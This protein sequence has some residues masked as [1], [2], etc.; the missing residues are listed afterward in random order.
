MATKRK[1]PAKIAPPTTRQ[2]AKK[3]LAAN[4]NEADTAVSNIDTH[5]PDANGD[6]DAVIEIS[7]DAGSSEYDLSDEE[8]DKNGE[9]GD[10]PAKKSGSRKTQSAAKDAH[11]IPTENGATDKAASPNPNQDGESDQE[12]AEPTF[13]ERLHA[14]ETID[15]PA[16]LSALRASVPATPGKTLAPP[17]LASLGTVLAQALRTDDT[18]LLESCLHT[19][20]VQTIRNT[21]QRLDSSLAGILL[22]KLASRMHRR[23][24]RAGTLMTWVQWALIAHGGALATQ[25]NLSKKLSELNK[26]LEERSRGLNSLLALKG[27]LDLLEA[28]MQLRRSM[29]RGIEAEEDEEAG[30]EEGLIYV[31]GQESDDDMI[32]G[33]M[34]VDEDDE[35]ALANGAAED[36][37]EDEESSNGEDADDLDAVEDDMDEN[38]VDFNDNESVDDEDS[39]IEAASPVKKARR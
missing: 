37:S 25:P 12:P 31:E 4:I 8:Q 32:N 28:Q 33:G 3:P 15:V 9:A 19:T 10:A 2:S 21:V 18:D 22:T 26:V 1:A 29:Q 34:D 6:V 11:L 27:K 20:D 30:R 17:S 16:A 13:G 14:E 36:D 7:S 38:E 35:M 5:N 39:D 24:G 23:P